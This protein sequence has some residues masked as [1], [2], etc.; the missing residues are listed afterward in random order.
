MHALIIYVN[1][2]KTVFKAFYSNT[3]KSDVWS[4]CTDEMGIVL[5]FQK[6]QLFLTEDKVCDS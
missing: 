3:A 5:E 2:L 6:S 1:Y 4:V